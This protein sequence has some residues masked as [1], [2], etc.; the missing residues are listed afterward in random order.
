MAITTD[1][2]MADT[3]P[4]VLENARFTEQFVAEMSKLVWRIRKELH[5]GKNI[6]VPTFG[7]VVA[8]DLAE[9]VDNVASET[10][11]DSLVTVTPAEV[12]C[13]LILTD[14]LVR[15]NQEDIKAAAGRILGN[16]MEVK[17]DQDILLQ[18]ASAATS[19]GSGSTATMG[20]V[21]AARVIIKGNP[22]S[23]GGPGPGSLACVLHPYVSLDLV[24]VLTPLAPVQSSGTAGYTIQSPAM[25]M[26]DEV[27]RQY[28]VGRLFGMPVIEDG[29]IDTTTIANTAKG[30]VF[31]TGEG[32]AIILGTALE[33]SVEPER[34]ASL[35]A[36]ELNIVGEYG[37][38]IYVD[39]WI[40]TM[41]HDATLPA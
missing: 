36:T 19:L 33:W 31:C 22:V 41:N 30:G 5:D 39:D 9:G 35:R 34:D 1:A 27:V 12:G 17:R 29:N 10:M 20:Q 6:N 40:V 14:K 32:G 4:T 25:A 38:G 11:S 15:D 21:A 23:N 16:A 7:T 37:V 13:K 8:R 26:V 3:V 24:D 2:V 18:L 28:G